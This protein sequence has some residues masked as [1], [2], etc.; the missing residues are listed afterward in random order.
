MIFATK[1]GLVSLDRTTGTFLWKYTY[2]FYP[3]CTSMGASP[4]VWSNLVYCTASYGRGAAAA[5][6]TLANGN[7]TVQQLY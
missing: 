3:I 2:P 6:I 7:W 1:T 5:R 4:V